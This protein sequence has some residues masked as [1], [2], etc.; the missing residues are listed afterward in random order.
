MKLEKIP[1]YLKENASWCNFNYESRKRNRIK[2]PYNPTTG[3]KAFVNKRET[4]TDFDTAVSAL[5][6]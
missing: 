4:F 6:D 3:Y 2:V 1:L 5:K